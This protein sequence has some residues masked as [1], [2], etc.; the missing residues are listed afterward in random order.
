MS[1]LQNIPSGASGLTVN[2]IL[3]FSP[4]QRRTIFPKRFRDKTGKF[5]KS[6]FQWVIRYYKIIDLNFS[7]N[8]VGP[9]LNSL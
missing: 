8:F 4:F 9:Y 1:S 2:A 5:I 3:M 7:T 6:K